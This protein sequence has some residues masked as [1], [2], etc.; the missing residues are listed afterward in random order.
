[1]LGDR[2]VFRPDFSEAFVNSGSGCPC[3]GELEMAAERYAGMLQRAGVGRGDTVA[4][5]LPN[6][7]EFVIS[8]FAIAR[9]QA[10][11]LPLDKVHSASPD[12]PALR[13]LERMQTADINQMPVVSDGHVIGMIARDAILRVLQTRLQAGHLAES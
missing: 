5:V 8:F 3:C 10:V 6:C 1:M 13:V 9:A 2:I 4:V 12:E 11:M 7:P